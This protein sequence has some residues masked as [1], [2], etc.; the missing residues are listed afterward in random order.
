[1]PSA[2]LDRALLESPAFDGR[3]ERELLNLPEKAVQ[4]GTGAFLRGFVEYFIDE[5]NRQGLFNGRVV[6]IGSTGS[7]RYEQLRSQDS[8]Y[9]LLIEGVAN[10][11]ERREY[12]LITSLSR[13][14]SAQTEWNAVLECAR[15]PQLE[16][17]FSNTTEI[18]IQLDDADRALEDLP[19][20]F[21]AKLTR[22][23]Y[24]RGRAFD[25]A[26]GSG[27]T[28]IPCELIE[29]NGDLLGALVLEQARRWNLEREFQLW[30]EGA[31]RYCN[32][33]VDRIVPGE[34]DASAKE[35]AAAEL[36]YRDE[37]LTI[38]EPYRL[39]AIKA[40]G[41][42]KQHLTF[43]A[44][45]NNIIV[46]ADIE[47]FRARKIRLLNGT[48]TIMTPLALLA[49]CA[50][51]H[52][53]LDDELV[54]DFT[55]HVLLNE[56]VPSSDV[57]DA[58]P[59]AREVL[60]RFANPFIHHALVDITLQQTMKMRVRVV[61]AIVDFSRRNGASPH[62]LAFGFAAFLLYIRDAVTPR[63][64]D[65]ADAIHNAWQ[66]H[67]CPP[68]LAATVC[69]D[70][71][72]WGADLSAVPGFVTE[73]GDALDSLLHTGARAALEAHL[74]A[75]SPVARRPSPGARTPVGPGA[76]KSEAR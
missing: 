26:A 44:A 1:M 48:H 39:F 18:G 74:R 71:E 41:E 3:I 57:A 43:A 34:A 67:A 14:L 24:V 75:S 56:L 33:L 6:A 37:L 9:T 7:G 25:Y 65:H 59:F 70:Q 46:A 31:V 52:A 29:N 12:R 32:T 60:D 28:V 20:S 17:I 15:N 21:P 30:L 22:F 40:D 66:K 51:V 54:G 62:G 35:S 50:T 69:A 64:D 23:L 8:L 10:G 68:E 63:A 49:G 27:I 13:A 47:P 5:A 53:A 42:T 36:G 2:H 19:H 16:L 76:R 38:C 61:P 58:E 45:D 72:L 4:F 55:R 73:V 11:E